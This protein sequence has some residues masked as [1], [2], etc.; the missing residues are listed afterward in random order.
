M[1]V[2]VCFEKHSNMLGQAA[3]W[4]TVCR[5]ASDKS[6]VTR[7][8]SVPLGMLFLSHLGLPLRT[9]PEEGFS[10]WLLQMEFMN[11]APVC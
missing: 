5:P 7:W 6:R 2:A 1:N 4:Q 9:A 11:F 3:S 8:Y 10:V